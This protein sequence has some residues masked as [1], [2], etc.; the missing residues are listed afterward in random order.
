MCAAVVWFI[1]VQLQKESWEG[2]DVVCGLLLKMLKCILS[3][4]TCTDIYCCKSHTKLFLF[5]FLTFFLSVD[6]KKN[7]VVVPYNPSKSLRID[8]LIICFYDLWI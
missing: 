7:V 1:N 2:M 4:L 3:F 5:Y 8:V 6:C